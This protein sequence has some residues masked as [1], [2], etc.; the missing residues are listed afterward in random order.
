MAT[1]AEYKGKYRGVQFMG[2]TELGKGCMQKP[3]TWRER[4]LTNGLPLG[5]PLVIDSRPR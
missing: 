2:P 1:P 5:S 3:C 4:E